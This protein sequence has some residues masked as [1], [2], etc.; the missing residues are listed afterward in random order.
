[1]ASRSE[2]FRARVKLEREVLRHLNSEWKGPKLMGLSRDGISLWRTSNV[3]AGCEPDSVDNVARILTD[4]AIKLRIEADS[5]RTVF[6][7]AVFET[8]LEPEL[9]QIRAIGRQRC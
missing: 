5:S 9:E 1:M 4:I 8:S 3:A 7:E 2:R 6:D